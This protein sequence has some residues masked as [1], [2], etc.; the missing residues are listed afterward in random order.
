MIGKASFVFV[1]AGALTTLSTLKNFS[2]EHA[3][4]IRVGL[5]VN[6][7]ALQVMFRRKGMIFRPV[8]VLFRQEIAFLAPRLQRVGRGGPDLHSVGIGRGE[9]FVAHTSR[10]ALDTCGTACRGFPPG[11]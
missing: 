4:P 10:L 11:P 8:L 3:G 6:G 2:D 5:G 1:E 9:E 7:P